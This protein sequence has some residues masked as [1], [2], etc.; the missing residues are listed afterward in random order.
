MKKVIAAQTAGA[1]IFMLIP[2]DMDSI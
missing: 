1:A 2:S